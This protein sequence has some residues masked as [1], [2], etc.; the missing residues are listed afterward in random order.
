MRT[1]QSYSSARLKNRKEKKRRMAMP[2]VTTPMMPVV[3]RHHGKEAEEGSSRSSSRSRRGILKPMLRV[4]LNREWPQ[5]QQTLRQKERQL[6][7][8]NQKRLPLPSMMLR[9]TMTV[10]TMETIVRKGYLRTVKG[11]A[12]KAQPQSNKKTKRRKRGMLLV[13]MVQQQLMSHLVRITMVKEK[14]PIVQ[15]QMRRLMTMMLTSNLTI[16]TPT[17]RACHLLGEM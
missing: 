16:S 17:R 2:V 6:N 9:A 14:R 13:S 1:M 7:P 5:K 11:I 3:Q 12:S 8:Q 10:E 15:V 4:R